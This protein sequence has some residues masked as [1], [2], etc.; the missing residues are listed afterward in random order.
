VESERSALRAGVVHDAAF[1]PAPMERCIQRGASGYPAALLELSRPP[2]EIH[3]RGALPPAGAR[4]VAIVG[5]RAATPYGLEHAERLAADLAGLGIVIVSGLARGIDAAAHRGALAAGGV[6]LAVLPG[7]L[8]AI[9]PTSHVGLARRIAR[10]GALLSEWPGA[11]P[12]GRGMFVRRNRLI[13]ALAGATVVVEAAERSGALSTAAVA[14]RLARPLFAVPGDVDRPTSRGCNALLRAGARFCESAADVVRALPAPAIP[15]EAGSD[16]SRL[17]AV[18][19]AE[20]LPAETLAARA[21]VAIGLALAG[22]LRLEWMG[23]AVAHPGQRWSR[24]SEP[25]A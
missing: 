9:T 6:T 16:E 7:G 8:D 2:R 11:F 1:A 18:L 12:V 15:V 25:V 14:R 17:A 24:R 22:L 19:G 4:A 3:V 10:R 5:S 13:A 21:G 23:E 20:P